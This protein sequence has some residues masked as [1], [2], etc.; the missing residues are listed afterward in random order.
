MRE[1]A[2]AGAV[3]GRPH[4]ADALV[5]RGVVDSREEAFATLLSSRG[6]YYVPHHAPDAVQA[7]RLVVEAGGVPVMAHPLA[8]QRGRVVDDEVIEAMAD[9]G[10]AGLEVDHRD[11]DESARSHLRALAARLDLLVTGSSDYHGAGKPNRLGEHTTDPES[12]E[13][14]ERLATGT[15]AVR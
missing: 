2:G 12:L 4:I 3:L 11:N 13:R 5:T 8:R 10:L 15:V 1:Q 9:A 14:I 6:P 7:V